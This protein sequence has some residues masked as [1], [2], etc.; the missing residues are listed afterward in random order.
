MIEESQADGMSKTFNRIIEE[1]FPKLKRYAYVDTRST[2]YT[3]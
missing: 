3:K 1:N 2:Q